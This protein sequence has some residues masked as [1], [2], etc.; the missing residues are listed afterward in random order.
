[1]SMPRVANNNFNPRIDVSCCQLLEQLLSQV[2]L[3]IALKFCF[4]EWSKCVRSGGLTT[5]LTV[6]PEPLAPGEHSVREADHF[7]KMRSL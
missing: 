1:M 3:R 7:R 6:A 2:V 4:E 5:C